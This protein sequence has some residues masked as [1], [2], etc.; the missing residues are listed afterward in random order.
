[1]AGSADAVR[2]GQL[3]EFELGHLADQLAVGVEG[4]GQALRVNVDGAVTQ[5]AADGALG[6]LTGGDLGKVGENGL[7]VKHGSGPF[8]LWITF[9]VMV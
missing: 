8:G 3:V 1:M 6:L 5:L 4:V 9:V 7:F 2:V